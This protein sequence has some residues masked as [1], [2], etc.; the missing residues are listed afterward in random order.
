MSLALP[1][2]RIR[3]HVIDA[4]TEGEPL[5]VVIGEAPGHDGDTI[6]EKRRRAREELDHLRR[7]LI[8]EP[9]G[10]AD[11]YAAVP[12]APVTPDGDVGVLFLHNEG[13]STMCGHGIIGLVKV[14]LEA[15]LFTPREPGV[16]R[17][18]T[19]AG[20]VTARPET[21][22]ER[23]VSVSF[24]NV[25]SFLLERDLAVEVEGLGELAVDV[26]YGGAFYALVDA[27]P[28]ALALE[29][30]SF[31]R[32]VELG[33][34]IKRAVAAACDIRHP[35][36]AED[37]GFLHGTILV[38]P[39]RGAVHSRNVCVFADGEVDRSPTGTGVSARAAALVARGEV[40]LGREIV[41]ESLV[42]TSFAVRAERTVRVGGLDAVVPVVRGRAWTTG[43]GELW[44]DPT[45]P[46]GG[47]FLLR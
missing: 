7:A 31:S 15:G 4:H 8:L 3:L 26:A 22:G 14:G 34:R 27:E 37:L 40:E 42:G 21:D 33:M 47:G 12:V 46:L 13:Y 23:V 6:L 32:I 35:E 18:D 24:E 28:L 17:I 2:D 1:E 45:D 43:Q 19:P 44:V 11:M 20:R 5:R 25:P 38:E 29:P 36:G 9:R 41:I 30:G 16:V 10:H 39:G